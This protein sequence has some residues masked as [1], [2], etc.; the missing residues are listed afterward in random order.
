MFTAPI[1]VEPR[2]IHREEYEKMVELGLLAGERVE[3]LYGVIVRMR[4]KGP[5]HDS[6]IQRL[7]SLL[8]RCYSGAQPSVFRARSRHP[9]APSPS[10]TSPSFLWASTGTAIRATP[11]S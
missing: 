3:L 9:M 4:P 2:P 11:S 6:A 7:T 1:P 10:R 8:V 5:P